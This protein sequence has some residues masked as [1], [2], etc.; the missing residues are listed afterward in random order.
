VVQ[1]ELDAVQ[2]LGF[3]FDVQEFALEAG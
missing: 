1:G 2:G 3:W